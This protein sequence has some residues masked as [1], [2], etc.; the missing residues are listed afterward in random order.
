VVGSLLNSGTLDA[1]QVSLTLE[2]VVRDVALTSSPQLQATLLGAVRS[3]LLQGVD[4]S[5]RLALFEDL[6]EV[7]H[8]DRFDEVN[9]VVPAIVRQHGSI[10]PALGAKYVQALLDVRL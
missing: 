9:V 2:R 1:V 3:H 5:I 8:R 6:I 7:I 10:P 4:E